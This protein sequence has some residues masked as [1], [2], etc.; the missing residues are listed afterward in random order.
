MAQPPDDLDRWLAELAGREAARG[1]RSESQALRRAILNE[2][3]LDAAPPAADDEHATEQLLFRLRREGLLKR[4]RLPAWGFA[5]AA[6]LA[7]AAV[8]LAVLRQATP[9]ATEVVAYA[10]PPIWRGAYA[11]FEVKTPQ[12]RVSAEKLVAALRAEGIQADIYAA[13]QVYTVDT[14]LA[15]PVKPA[16]AAHFKAIGLAVKPGRVRV[17]FKP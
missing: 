10:E 3:R 12:P 1:E 15:D 16:L 14:E 7:A 17:E 4:R 2:A 8:G 5:L 9:P 6:T 13:A 11:Q